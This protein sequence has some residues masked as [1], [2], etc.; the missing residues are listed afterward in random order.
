[1]CLE[2]GL[3]HSAPE[4]HAQSLRGR[5]PWAIGVSHC[6]GG[7]RRRIRT[8]IVPERSGARG[9]TSRHPPPST[10][11]APGRSARFWKRSAST[12]APRVQHRNGGS[13]VPPGISSSRA[14]RGVSPPT[15]RTA[16]AGEVAG[17]RGIVIED[18]VRP[19]RPRRK[20]HSPDGRVSRSSKL[21][22]RP[23]SDAIR[24]GPGDV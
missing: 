17:R 13:V 4:M 22:T 7:R 18:G 16:I 11:R 1:M 24:T 10:L 23:K 9:S 8:R 21:L 5:K 6:L 2:I 15:T 20:F 12:A 3:L 19:L 14:R